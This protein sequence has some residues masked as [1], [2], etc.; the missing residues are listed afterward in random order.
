[1]RVLIVTHNYP[2][3]AGDP[4]GAFVARLA[5]ATAASG[6]TV[7]VLAP[8]VAGTESEES[9]NGVSIRRFRYA[10]AAAERVG[11]RGDLH[12][13]RWWSSVMVLGVPAFL[14]AF[15][16]A[17]RREARRFRPTLVHAHWWLPGGLLAAVGTSVP[18]V[19]TCH[20][21]DVRLLDRSAAFRAL[22]RRVFARAARVTTV[23]EFLA[24]DLAAVVPALRGRVSVTPMPVDAASFAAGRRE[25]KQQPPRIL[26]AG[27]L[28]VSKGVD[29]LVE[30]LAILR[31]RGV[32]CALKV[33][34]AGPHEPA[35]RSLVAAR[36]LA[37]GVEFAAF[38]PQGR[39]P[40]EY[41]RATVTVLPTRGR[42]E[43]LGLTLVEALL[44][45]SAVVGTRVG[46]IPEVV[47]DGATGLLV[48]PED[49]A[50]LAAALQR[51]LEDV[52]L[53]ERLTAEGRARA[54]ATYGAAP[55]S[56]RMLALYD[57]VLVDRR[58]A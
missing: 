26:Y 56:R 12:Q 28:L 36:G 5:E 55:A 34:G 18:L 7:R 50:A 47:D 46:G 27:N 13:Q 39:M 2:R 35:L 41:G 48:A 51:L 43:G 6:A 58:A 3:F 21:S 15:A 14:L 11:Y 44:A 54:A 4:A 23:S 38:V 30:A 8:H 53:R 45:G 17:V 57:D 52:A 22:A 42:H 20:G 1:M 32:A 16:V 9:V 10:P 40:E 25:A 19:V 49:P 37:E 33:L 29:D 24:R 31:A